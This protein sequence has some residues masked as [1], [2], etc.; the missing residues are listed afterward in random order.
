MHSSSSPRPPLQQLAR[1]TAAMSSTS[2][3]SFTGSTSTS[4]VSTAVPGVTLP[5]GRFYPLAMAGITTLPGLSPSVAAAAAM[6]A[7]SLVQTPFAQLKA[8]TPF[9]APTPPT[10]TAPAAA[11]SKD[12]EGYIVTEVRKLF[13]EPDGGQARR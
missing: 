2:T 8:A 4:T 12:S 13:L 5:L 1:P 3:P 10:T 6:S 9:R 7:S 11:A